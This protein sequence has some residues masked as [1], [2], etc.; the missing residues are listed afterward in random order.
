MKLRSGPA[1]VDLRAKRFEERFF[2]RLRFEA[3]ET[4]KRRK[5]RARRS[6]C[7]FIFF[8]SF[9]DFQILKVSSYQV[10]DDD[11]LCFY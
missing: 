9:W 2:F 10:D 11:E 1:I 7:C 4:V 8:L 5:D 3:L 6:L